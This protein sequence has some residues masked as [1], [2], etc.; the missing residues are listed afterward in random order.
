MSTNAIK[1]TTYGLN[2][3]LIT[4]PPSPILAKRAPS[5][6]DKAQLA[7]TWIDQV[8]DIAYI[9]TSIADNES[10]WEEVGPGAGVNVVHANTGSA[11][12]SGG[13]MSFVGG[14]NMTTS[15]TASTVT[16]SLGNS[17]SVSST[18]TAGTGI[19]ATTGDVKSTA[20][21]IVLPAASTS[22]AGAIVAGTVPVL[23]YTGTGNIFVGAN[24][25]N[26]TTT[27]TNNALY[28]AGAAAA[29]TTGSQNVIL[30]NKAAKNA[31]TFSYNVIAGYQ[32]GNSY[33]TN[34]SSNIVISNSGTISDANTIR[35]GTQGTGNGQQN[36]TFIAGITG[37]TV[38]GAAVLCS[39]AGQLGTISSS[40][41]FKENIKDIGD[42]SKDIYSLRPVHFNYKKDESKLI[43]YGLIAEEVRKTFPSLVLYDENGLPSSVA[44]HELPTLL[45]NE[46]KKLREEFDEL[47]KRTIL[48]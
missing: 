32:S 38:T 12:G 20:G 8:G 27:G 23:Q 7:T 18:I 33:T 13:A 45:L 34:E 24:A 1:Q 42:N 10:N 4:N 44:Y 39:T 35:I 40:V 11:T 47:K 3:G 14:T 36:T 43:H 6:F 46:L 37:A 15:A 5:I 25:A 31:T 22:T 21:N 29:I 2:Q 19:T 41:R 9:L 26:F 48:K 16:I 17:I 28:G 30:G